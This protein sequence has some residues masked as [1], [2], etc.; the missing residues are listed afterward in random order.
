MTDKQNAGDDHL[1]VRLNEAFERLENQH[2]E[3]LSTPAA[4]SPG[5]RSSRDTQPASSVSGVLGVVLALVGIGIASY[6]A[7]T[8]YLQTRQQT[9]GAVLVPRLDA[10]DQRLDS[11]QTQLNALGKQLESI[12]TRV[13]N[14]ETA[15]KQD[16]DQLQKRV[17]ASVAQMQANLGTSSKDWLYAEVEYLLRLANQRVIMEGNVQGALT[18]F[19]DADNIIRQSEGITAFDLRRAIAD[20]IAQ[21]EAVSEVDVDGIYVRLSALAGQVEQLQQQK[22]VF[23]PHAVAPHQG[24]P[25]TGFTAQLIDTLKAAGARLATLVDFRRNGERIKPVLPP[26]EEYYLRQNL[27]LKI[28]MAQ[29][30]L[31]RGDQPVYANS[32][33]E[34]QDWVKLHFDQG[35]PVTVAMLKELS[36]LAAIDIARKMPDVSSSLKEVRKL[37]ASFQIQPPRAEPA[38]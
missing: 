24:T 20:N 34:A 18:L 26:K 29:L 36:N 12:S 25:G 5:S 2:D 22:Q 6:A 4:N 16:V 15:N 33:S 7:W 17:E 23:K 11:D 13:G 19:R 27:V 38:K 9:V 31:L 8:V 21:L 10:V 30:A 35:D 28:Q 1:S 32:L 14:V 3:N 37:M